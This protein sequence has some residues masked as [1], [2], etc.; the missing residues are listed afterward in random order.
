METSKENLDN[1]VCWDLKGK[2]VE[3][4]EPSG[5]NMF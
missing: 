5:L 3:K 1:D 4:E 2:T